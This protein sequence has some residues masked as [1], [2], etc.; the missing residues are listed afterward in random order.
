[1]ASNNVIKL[2]VGWILAFEIITFVML[3]FVI[4]K[5]LIKNLDVF[6]KGLFNFFSF[7]NR[8]KNDIEPLVKDGDDEIGKMVDS[9]NKEINTIKKSYAEDAE[10]VSNATDITK[11]IAEGDISKRITISTTNP[12]L[13]ELKEVFNSMLDSL[14]KEVGSDMNSISHSLQAYINMDFTQANV[15]STSTLDTMIAQLGQDISLMLVK[16]SNDAHKLQDKSNSLNEFV[17]K[18][19]NA[20]NEQS[21]STG[22]TSKATQEITLSLN[23]MVEQAGAVGSQSQEIK[24]V[25]TVISDIADQTNLLALNAAIEAARAG[26]HGRGFAVVADEVRK[27]AERTQKSLAEINISVSTLVQSISGI[28]DGLEQQSS[29][30]ENFNEFIEQMNLNTENSLEI[31]KQTGE[32]AKDLDISAIAIL[33]DV[34]SKKFQK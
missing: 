16:N 28:V 18:L 25:I 29:K 4:N 5:F 17:G 21:E 24:N 31:A 14:E 23:E 12:R 9:I 10:L 6:S 30:L 26:E 27:L 22:K 11:S 3:L 8:K 13:K 7:L 34:N 33:E 1:M 15:D 2:T 20:A 19:I 32:L